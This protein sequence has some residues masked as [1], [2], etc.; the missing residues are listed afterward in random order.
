LQTLN[1][2]LVQPLHWIHRRTG[3]A[4]LYFV[5][6]PTPR[7]FRAGCRF[8][9]SGKIPELW[10]AETGQTRFAPIW[11]EEHGGTVVDLN[12][13][14][15]GAEFVV[16]RRSSS[17]TDPVVNLSRDGQ[18]YDLASLTSASED[19]LDLLVTRP[20][21]YSVRFA[22]GRHLETR[23]EAVPH[24]I[25]VTGPWDVSFPGKLGSARQVS[26]DR[27]VSWTTS[28]NTAI[29]FFSG[30]ARYQAEFK[31]AEEIISP[32]ND[33]ILSLGNVQVIAEVD[34]NGVDFG[35][36]WKPPFEVNV[37][38]AVK[39]GRNVLAIKVTNLWPNRLIGDEQ[40]PDDSTWQRALES[41][42]GYP[43]AEWP[44]WL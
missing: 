25:E 26:F 11:H 6:N 20:G 43:I 31:V 2:G 14:P 29:K 22:S 33:L 10:N 21:S 4:D 32:H 15:G 1:S 19:R 42:S 34:L 9:V 28:T 37:T 30:T 36:L 8:R 40:L 24:P 27:L 5:A 35:V 39:P 41:D 12:L 18:L 44:E 13:D 3:E 7:P 17:G 38:N 16:F 23:I